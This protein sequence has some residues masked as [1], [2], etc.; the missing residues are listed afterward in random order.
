MC[1]DLFLSESIWPL[2]EKSSNFNMYESIP[3][4]VGMNKEKE[5]F[6]G[7]LGDRIFCILETLVFGWFNVTDH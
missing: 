1:Y 6:W 3:Q 7:W 5:G 2:A 4:W